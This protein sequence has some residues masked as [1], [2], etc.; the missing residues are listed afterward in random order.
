MAKKDLLSDTNL[1]F[2]VAKDDKKYD[3]PTVQVFLPELENSG[4]DGIPVDQYEHVTIANEEGE[5]EWRILRGIWQEIPVPAFIAL[6][7][8][9]PKL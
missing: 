4:D 1:T 9:Y 2:A 8:K 5:R 7:E 6:K 3:G